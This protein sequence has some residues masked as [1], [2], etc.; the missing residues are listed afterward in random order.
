[1]ALNISFDDGYYSADLFITSKGNLEGQW[2]LNLGCSFQ[3]CL[4]SHFFINMSLLMVVE[5]L[6][7]TPINVKLL[8]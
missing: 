3:I 8:E 6:W 7:E 5:F 4:I 1:M 2:V